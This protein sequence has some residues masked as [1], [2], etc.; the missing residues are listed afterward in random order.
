MCNSPCVGIC[1][2]NGNHC[3]G[4]GRH[5]DDIADWQLMSDEQKREAI[6]AA[7]QRLESAAREA[8]LGR[9][10]ARRRAEYTNNAGAAQ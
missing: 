1:K 4:C 3:T 6:W 2:V 5:I 7:G 9:F 8:F 10:R